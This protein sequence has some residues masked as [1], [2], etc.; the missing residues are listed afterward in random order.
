MSDPK[1]ANGT[2]PEPE[3][4]PLTEEQQLMVEVDDAVH[5]VSILFIFPD[6]ECSVFAGINKDKVVTKDNT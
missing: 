2:E 6:S 4:V 3:P 1:A 5:E